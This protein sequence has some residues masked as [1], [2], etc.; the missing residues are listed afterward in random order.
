MLR[1]VPQ[2]VISYILASY[3]LLF[4]PSIK[5]LPALPA[6]NIHCVNDGKVSLGIVGLLPSLTS[7]ACAELF[8]IEEP[9]KLFTVRFIYSASKWQ[10]RSLKLHE[11]LRLKDYPDSITSSLSSRRRKFLLDWNGVPLRVLGLL[12]RFLIAPIK[13]TGVDKVMTDVVDCVS[14]GNKIGKTGKVM[15]D[16]FMTE[17]VVVKGASVGDRVGKVDRIMTDSFIEDGASVCD[18]VGKLRNNLRVM[19]YLLCCLIPCLMLEL[20]FGSKKRGTLLCLRI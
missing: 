16:K 20:R 2:V 10:L 13:G 6:S 1:E 7:K 11:L 8:P 14:V 18:K 12:L 15:N 19:I 9:S 17:S 3:N 5:L 4:P